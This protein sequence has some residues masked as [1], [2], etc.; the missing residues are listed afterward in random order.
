[1]LPGAGRESQYAS[2]AS[3]L[4][5]DPRVEVA[6]SQLDAL[7]LS[8]TTPTRSFVMTTAA[9][10]DEL[11]EQIILDV[12]LTRDIPHDIRWSFYKS[13]LSL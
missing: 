8:P 12:W 9:L 3:T 2:A 1:M 4:E 7:T 11:V 13:T 6:T 5:T 10:P